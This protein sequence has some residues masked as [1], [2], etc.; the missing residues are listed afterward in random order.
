MSSGDVWI[1]LVTG[2]VLD[3]SSLQTNLVDIIRDEINALR[4]DVY[5]QDAT[6][7]TALATMTYNASTLDLDAT[8]EAVTPRGYKITAVHIDAPWVFVPFQDTAATNYYVGARWQLRPNTVTGNTSDGSIS[9]DTMIED[10]G[11]LGAPDSVTD[12]GNGTIT[13]VIDTLAQHVWTVAGTRPVVV[14]LVDPVTAGAEAIYTGTAEHDTGQIVITIPHTLG[15]GASPS[16]TPADYQVILQG[17]TITTT[18][19]S[20]N[21]EYWVIGE[22][23]TGVFTATAQ[24]LL[25][26]WGSWSSLFAAEHNLASGVHTAITPDSVLVS[27]VSG[28]KVQTRAVDVPDRQGN[29]AIELLDEL[30]TARITMTPNEG[31]ILSFPRVDL[32]PGGAAIVDVQRSGAAPQTSW[33]NLTNGQAN[34]SQAYLQID[35]TIR[36]NNLKTAS[37]WALEANDAANM[38]LRVQNVGA[39]RADLLLPAGD[40]ILSAGKLTASN[41]GIE[42]QGASAEITYLTARARQVYLPAFIPARV[43]SGTENITD[44]STP[45]KI[46]SNTTGAVVLI[47]P[48]NRLWLDSQDAG[49]ELDTFNCRHRRNSGTGS[50]VAVLYRA[51]A[52]GS[53]ARSAVSTLTATS[54]SGLW[55]ISGMNTTGIGHTVSR[56]YHYWIELTIDPNGGTAGD[57]EVQGFGLYFDQANIV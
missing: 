37:V 1:N 34:N 40:L 44:T 17:P 25:P 13:L 45:P 57:Y 2:Q 6:I 56:N 8:R 35:G 33:L 15:Q 18:N 28:V 52:D 12:N 21:P 51:L 30:G 7:G 22:V 32:S 3:F 24:N 42:L 43:A 4:D 47:Y 14:W 5:G 19:L 23:N 26:T 36:L 16:T 10:V 48:L 27:G 46:A 49:L 55:T 41:T 29:P 50:I 31:G 9:Y 11:E 53:G 38:T 20:T 54:N 39:G